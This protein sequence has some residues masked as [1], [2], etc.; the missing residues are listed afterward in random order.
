MI[1]QICGSIARVNVLP[2]YETEYEQEID[3]YLESGPTIEMCVPAEIAEQLM[4]NIGTVAMF[5]ISDMTICGQHAR[6]SGF[7]FSN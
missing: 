6:A 2:E 1:K 5:D 7:K 3:I 4:Q